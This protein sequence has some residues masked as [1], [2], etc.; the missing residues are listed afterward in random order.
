MCLGRHQIPGWRFAPKLMKN[1]LISSFKKV[2]LQENE[3]K[4][5]EASKGLDSKDRKTMIAESLSFPKRPPWHY[6]MPKEVLEELE[7][8]YFEKYKSELEQ[9][10]PQMGFHERN[11]EVWRQLWR[12]IEMS[13]ILLVLGDARNPL[14]HF[15]STLYDYVV[16]EKKKKLILILNKADLVS[17]ETLDIWKSYLSTQFP[18]LTI[19]YFSCNPRPPSDEAVPRYYRRFYR[20][21]G[22]LEVMEACKNMNIKKKG[23]VMDWEKVL[24]D[25]KEDLA[26]RDRK[27]MISMQKSMTGREGNREGKKK[28][29]RR[30]GKQFNSSS[31]SNS[32]EEVE[33]KEIE[34]DREDSLDENLELSSELLNGDD[35][36]E[37]HK[38]LTIGFIGHPNVGKS[39]LLN[40]LKGK[41]FVSVSKQPGHTK[42]FQ[43]IFLTNTLRLC[44][45]PGLVFPSLYPHY[46]QII[47]G[48]YSISQVQ[49]PFEA[50][51]YVAE[52]L[53]LAKQLKL[54][55]PD[56]KEDKENFQWSPW[57][58]CEA[59]AL[60]KGYLTAK[61][62]RP[63]VHRAAN[64]LLR[65]I[66]EGKIVLSLL[67]P[68]WNHEIMQEGLK[69]ADTTATQEEEEEEE[70]EEEAVNETEQHHSK[71]SKK[72]KKKD[73]KKKRLM[74]L[75][76]VMDSD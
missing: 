57:T 38:Y 73:Q 26:E 10:Y 3:T 11:L 32:E 39:S 37:D 52:R 19:T 33:A 54:T 24:L 50:I 15:P 16:K 45:C 59:L 62:G 71:I 47:S 76:G 29:G 20:A 23:V 48:I 58:I 63:D 42:H 5:L 44:D 67:P 1:P 4:K 60:Q 8:T 30:R 66:C 51:R 9:E 41:K 36:R 69:L 35:P 7:N 53:D 2:N 18:E 75:V 72:L 65:I 14:F 28:Y 64:L 61:S 34:E 56:Q 40:A 21:E 43:T 27:A 46:I 12:T 55:H 6:E 31:N 22:V 49:Q 74:A 70:E 25:L 13:D 68:N 17:A